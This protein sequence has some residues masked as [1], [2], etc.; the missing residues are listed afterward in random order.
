MIQ[1]GSLEL[2]I[3]DETFLLNEGDSFSLSGKEQYV[4]RNPS[5][6]DDCIAVWV[7]TEGY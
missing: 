5:N 7:I 4:A 2:T 6:T 1:S 3:D